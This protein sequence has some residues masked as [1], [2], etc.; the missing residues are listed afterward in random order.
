M[1]ALEFSYQIESLRDTLAI[2]TKKFTQDK[3]DAE[4]LIQDTILKALTYR[5]KFVE[6]TNL[7]GWLYTIMRNTYINSYRKL[8]KSKTT[9][10]H[11][12]NLF[13]LNAKEEYTFNLPDST[14][15]YNDIEKAISN[16]RD[17]YMTPFKMYFDGFKYHEIAE[18]LDIPLGTVKARIFKA[19]QELKSELP[20]YAY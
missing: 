10:D 20:Q 18:K 8:S 1:T 19:R 6:N 2:F 4:D 3:Q 13:H 9:L 7:K 16:V 5:D 11:T 17:E 12:E 14:I 15:E